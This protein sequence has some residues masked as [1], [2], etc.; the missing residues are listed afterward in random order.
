MDDSEVLEAYQDS[1][2][3]IFGQIR[4]NPFVSEG[5]ANELLGEAATFLLKNI[6]ARTSNTSQSDYDDHIF[7]MLHKDME[8]AMTAKLVNSGGQQMPDIGKK[9]EY[10]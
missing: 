9:N 3:E 6:I 10:H 4:D 2:A 7:I 5:A 1:L 8:G